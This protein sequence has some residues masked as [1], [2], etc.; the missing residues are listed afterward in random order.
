[1]EGERDGKEEE[2]RDG[3]GG[4]GRKGWFKADREKGGGDAKYDIHEFSMKHPRGTSVVK[5][6]EAQGMLLEVCTPGEYAD[7]P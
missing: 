6:V 3:G 7:R 5:S 1:M 4:G 2:E